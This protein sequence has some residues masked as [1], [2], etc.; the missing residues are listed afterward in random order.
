MESEIITLR[1]HHIYYLS[2][3]A[4]DP[5]WHEKILIEGGYYSQKNQNILKNIYSMLIKFSA[6]EPIRIKLVDTL[7]DICGGEKNRCGLYKNPCEVKLKEQDIS[8]IRRE[9]WKVN[10]IIDAN[11]LL[12]L[13]KIDQRFIR[14]VKDKGIDI[15][16]KKFNEL[17]VDSYLIKKFTETHK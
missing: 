1:G 11:P 8:V 14:E 6:Q 4:G 9:G 17:G 7:D 15:C 13:T 2:G 12:R 5:G 16:I 10:E 3:F